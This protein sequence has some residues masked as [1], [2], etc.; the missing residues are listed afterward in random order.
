MRGVVKITCWTFPVVEYFFT[1]CLSYLGDPFGSI[2][3]TNAELVPILASKG[4]QGKATKNNPLPGDPPDGF[5][6]GGG[7]SELALPKV[8]EASILKA[9]AFES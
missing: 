6:R 9:N 2:W 7:A 4:S 5:A 8:P 3:T 1:F